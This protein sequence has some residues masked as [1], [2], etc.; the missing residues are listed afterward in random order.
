LTGCGLSSSLVAFACF[1]IV[2]D[3]YGALRAALGVCCIVL[4]H[5]AE[6]SLRE[7]VVP[8]RKDTTASDRQVSCQFIV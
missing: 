8:Y 6:Y 1:F 2:T 3:Y 5:G 7:V 4:I